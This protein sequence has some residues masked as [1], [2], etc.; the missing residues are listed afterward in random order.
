[1]L[2]PVYNSEETL[3]R[4]IRSAMRQSL[5]DIEILVADDASTDGSF[6]V[7][8]A[9]AEGD[10]R[11]RVLQLAHNGGKPRAMN[12][13]M[14]EA[15]GD[16]VAVLD[17]DDAFVETRLERLIAA[18]EFHGVDMAADNQ[19][20]IDAGLKEGGADGTVL[21]LA[22]DPACG[23]RLITLSDL[24]AEADSFGDFDFGLLKPVIRRRFVA[25][26]RLAYH[27]ASR[28]AEDFT[29]LM[30]Y[31]VAGGRLVLC[32]EAFYR[33]TMPFGTVSRRWT[34]TGAG[35]WRYDYRAALAANAHFIDRMTQAGHPEVVRMLQRR[36]RQYR[37]MIPYLDAQRLAAQRR[38]LGAAA[39]IGTHPVC[40]GLLGRRVAGRLRRAIGTAQTLRA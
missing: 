8:R 27:E 4:C 29:Y 17:A 2:I 21:R 9:L 1:V 35:A 7:A 34:T 22:F 6:S 5:R 30:N 36:G 32:A 14:G 37:A 12:I 20:Y 28:L 40:W 15:R 33:W 31:L 16:W 25:E 13:M 24:V 26:H 19:F 23:E 38:F 3:D 11:I 18:A 39:L 10:A